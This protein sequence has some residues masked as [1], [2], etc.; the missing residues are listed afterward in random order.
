MTSGL[1]LVKWDKWGREELELE[2]RRCQWILD[3]KRP[4]TKKYE[5]GD[6]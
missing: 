4:S 6:K 1:L 2:I 5:V 3:L